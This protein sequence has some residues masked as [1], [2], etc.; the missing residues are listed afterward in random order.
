MQIE[1]VMEQLDRLF[2]WRVIGEY[3]RAAVYK[4]V[5]RQQSPVYLQRFQGIGEVVHQTLGTQCQQVSF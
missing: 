3:T 4:H 1:I 5:A 2:F